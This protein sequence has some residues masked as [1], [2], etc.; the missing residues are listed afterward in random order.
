MRISHK[1]ILV[2]S[3]VIIISVTVLTSYST[4]VLLEESNT[5][6]AARFS[7]MGTAMLNRL[8][9]QIS[10]MDLVVGE[11]T[12]NTTFMAALNQFVRDDSEDRKMA[13]AARN[14]LQQQLYHSPLVDYFYRV[15]IY[16]VNGEF[17][18]S[19]AEKDDYLVSGTEKAREVISALSWLELVQAQPTQ[20]HI[21]PPHNDTFSV[22]RDTPVYGIVHGVMFHGKLIAYIEVSDEYSELEEIMGMVDEPSIMTKAVFDN[23]M[24]LYETKAEHV[25]YPAT[26]E[27]N[28]LL[29]WVDEKQNLQQKVMVIRSDWLSMNIYVAQDLSI[30]RQ[31]EDALRRNTIRTAILIGVPALL[32]ITLISVGLTR[33]IRKLTKKV[34]QLPAEHVLLNEPETMQTL[35]RN[36]TNATDLE[37]FELENVFNKM[38]RRLRDST[39]NELASRE[40]TLQAQLSAL[41]TPINPHFI[42]NTLNIISAKSMESGNL[43]I[44]EICDQF[45]QMLRYSTD[46][47][48]RTATMADEIENVRNYLLLAKARYEEN[49]EFEIDIPEHLTEITLP[50]LALQPLVENAL[51]HG[52]DG[53]NMKRRL[54]I[55]GRIE[56]GQLI[57]EIHDNGTGFSDENLEKLRRQIRDVEEGKTTVEAV[58]AHIGLVNTCLRLHYYSHGA[59]HIRIHNDHGAVVTLTIPCENKP[60]T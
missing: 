31:Q 41:Q 9:Q 60:G 46:T 22:R 30:I 39:M 4:Q 29:D 50:K 37:I 36:V 18:T 32:I 12:D 55:T 56:G 42:Y 23:G 13:N 33:S 34:R 5:Y 20:R 49:L 19:K 21:L 51:T 48:S 17:I 35:S 11:L 26:L 57:L 28:I 54:T 44:I 43:E 16:T 47:R 52:Y 59:T 14:T 6:T 53:Q 25:V 10:M 40:G 1:M 7:N 8:E 45:A 2:F 24:V 15:S 3:I 27:D 38:I 58:G